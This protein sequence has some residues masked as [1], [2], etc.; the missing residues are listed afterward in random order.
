MFGSGFLKVF[1]CVLLLLS[2]VAEPENHNHQRGARMPMMVGM[3]V[4]MMA[5][6]RSNETHDFKLGHDQ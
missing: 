4:R 1:S 2:F 3:A 6:L 5:M